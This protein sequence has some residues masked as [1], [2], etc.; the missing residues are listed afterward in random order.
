VVVTQGPFFA[1]QIK[2]GVYLPL[3]KSKLPNWKNLD[4]H[5]LA[6]IA[7]FDPGNAHAMPYLRATTGLTYNVA[8]IKARMADAPTDS[9]AMIFDPKVA[10][11]FADCGISLLDSANDVLQSALA[12]LHLDPNSTKPEDYKAAEAL[13]MA[14]RPYIRAFD[15]TE[16]L[17]AL[18]NQERCLAMTWSVDYL[19]AT[20][21]AKAAGSPVEFAFVLPKEG[22]A[23]ADDGMLIPAS[24][25]HPDNA[26]KFLNFIL[27]P[28]VTAEI[29]NVTHYPNANLAANPYVDPALLKNPVIYLSP[30]T[31]QRLYP[32]KPVGPDLDRLKTRIWTR[33]K[34]G[35]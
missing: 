24:A 23:L 15:S 33:I 27:E 34:T 7:P 18:P 22:S 9:L 16:F 30:D 21:R 25:P 1:R 8:M 28:K 12:Y 26:H 5:T 17:N 31:V 35:R 10:A 20:E 14:V 11:K 3:D 6:D 2:A 4:P 13:V 29:T 32:S 19:T